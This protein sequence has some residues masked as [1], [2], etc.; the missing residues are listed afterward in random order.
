MPRERSV[1]DKLEKMSFRLIDYYSNTLELYHYPFSR[2][3]YDE[4][5]AVY[6][7][8]YD[9]QQCNKFKGVLFSIQNDSLS[10][11]NNSEMNDITSLHK[12]YTKYDIGFAIG[13]RIS[14]GRIKEDN[15]CYE[16]LEIDASLGSITM[17]LRGLIW[18]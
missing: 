18:N 14:E 9:K 7:R 13:D 5:T 3:N 10:D 1:L 16:I 2:D 6:E 17:I 11:I 15:F 12:L 8:I 4:E